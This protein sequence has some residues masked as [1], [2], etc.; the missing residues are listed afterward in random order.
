MVQSRRLKLVV[1]GLLCVGTL[2][3]SLMI[4]EPEAPKTVD[5]VM[6]NPEL[7]EGNTISLRGIVA[8]GSIDLNESVFNLDGEN[9][10]LEI[11]YGGVM[12][13]DAFSEGKTIQV[14]G[15]LFQVQEKWTLQAEEIIVGCPSKYDV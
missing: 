1:V 3:I 9:M 13:S 10:S 15:K 5:D 12:V 2:M 14:K 4:Q 7:H 11:E 6:K 8:N